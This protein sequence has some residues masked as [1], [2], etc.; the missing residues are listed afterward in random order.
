MSKPLQMDL[1]DALKDLAQ[2]FAGLAIGDKFFKSLAAYL[3]KAL[4]VDY[5]FIGELT[6]KD[7]SVR[8]VAFYAKG[9]IVDNIEYPLVGSLCEQVV[10]PK[11]CAYPKGVQEMF[12]HNQALKDFGVDSYVGTPLFD[13]YGKVLGLIYVMHSG[14]IDKLEKTESLLRIVA[15]RA[16]LELEREQQE[17]WLQQAN[18]ELEQRVTQRTRALLQSEQALCEKMKQLESINDDLENFIYTASHDLKAPILNIEGL[19]TVLSGKLS[20]EGWQDQTTK[21]I[22]G[23]M[24]GSVGRFKG[25]VTDLTHI[26]KIDKE[27][28]QENRKVDLAALVKEVE[29]DLG[30]QIKEAKAHVSL[31]LQ[32]CPFIL[33]SSKRLKSIVY[34]LLSNALK[35]CSPDREL[36][37]NISCSKQDDYHVLTVEDNG[38]GMDLSKKD[39]IFA[40]FK[41]LHDHVEGSGIGLYIVKKI[42]EKAGGKIEVDSKLDQGSVFRVYFKQ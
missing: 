2:G 36:H 25:T 40:L 42:I 23:M 6:N 28:G 19:L 26:I 17:K 18:Q 3:S 22:I 12:P 14:P 31:Q 29:A 1:D 41:R 7:Q 9:Q 5:V 16:E 21:E 32:D 35:Y 24:Q 39:K 38:L 37:I 27:S 34:N 8:S 20:Q 4:G 11:F 30:R 33:F 10:K 15:K 13:T